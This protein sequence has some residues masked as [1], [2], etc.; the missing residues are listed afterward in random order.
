[1]ISGLDREPMAF[2]PGTRAAM[3][4]CHRFAARAAGQAQAQHVPEQVVV[5][6][7]LAPAVQG[8]EKQIPALQLFEQQLAVGLRG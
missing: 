7:P 4:R 3:E 5:A 6:V 1:M 8:H 2:E